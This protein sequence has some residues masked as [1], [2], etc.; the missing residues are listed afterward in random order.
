MSKVELVALGAGLAAVLVAVVWRALSRRRSRRLMERAITDLD[1]AVR[2]AAIRLVTEVSLA[3]NAG[4]LLSRVKEEDDPTVIEELVRSVSR[5]QWEPTDRPAVVE[6]RL[7]AGRRLE[8]LTPKPVTRAHGHHPLPHPA[9]STRPA[10][11]PVAPSEPAPLLPVAAEAV[12]WSEPVRLR[13]AV[14]L[15]VGSLSRVCVR[16]YRLRRTGRSEGGHPWD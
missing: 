3:R 14:L 4:L 15:T 9:A 5:N 8:E 2:R 6:L 11:L 7:W 13:R 12:P 1:P 10:T 16:E